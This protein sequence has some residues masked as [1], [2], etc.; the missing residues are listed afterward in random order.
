MNKGLPG[1]KSATGTGVPEISPGAKELIGI[2]Y[3]KDTEG[4]LALN[5]ALSLCL[6]HIA[7][8][9][10][11]C[12]PG[13][14]RE[15]CHLL[16]QEKLPETFFGFCAALANAIEVRLAEPFQGPPR[17]RSAPIEITHS[18]F[19]ALGQALAEVGRE[20][21]EAQSPLGP[22]LDVALQRLSATNPGRLQH[23]LIPSLPRKR[24]PGLLR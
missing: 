23:L 9:P 22:N 8:L 5:R 20:P 10:S 19:L 14:H 18:V 17:G 13:D 7:Q 24:S 11:L 12:R 1:T 16:K 6:Q 21:K 2:A 4:T 3:R 15:L